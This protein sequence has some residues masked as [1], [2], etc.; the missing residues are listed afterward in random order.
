MQQLLEMVSSLCDII[1]HVASSI[2]YKFLGIIRFL[3]C[4]KLN[5]DRAE[6]ARFL[7]ALVV[8]YILGGRGGV[9]KRIEKGALRGPVCSSSWGKWIARARTSLSTRSASQYQTGWQISNIIITA[10]AGNTTLRAYSILVH[11]F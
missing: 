4:R 2:K 10:A 5:T 11:T 8:S 9:E 7:F 1:F 6:R 3:S